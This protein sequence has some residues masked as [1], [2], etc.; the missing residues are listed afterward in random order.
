MAKPEPGEGSDPACATGRGR[1]A[2]R[3]APTSMG[4]LCAT[5]SRNAG[6]SRMPTGY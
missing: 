4:G 6:P 3:G 5:G 1:S 2:A